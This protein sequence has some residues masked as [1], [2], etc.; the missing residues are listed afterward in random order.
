M[1]STA[2]IASIALF[3]CAGCDCGGDD[4]P[5]PC[6]VDSAP[7]GCGTYCDE[8]R[9]C[10]PGFFC[11]LPSNECTADCFT[12]TDCATN[13]ACNLGTGLCYEVIRPDA[14]PRDGEPP[15]NEGGCAGASVTARRVTPNVILIVDQSS[16]MNEGF[17]GRT[18]WQALRRSLLD[19]DDG[20]IQALD[21]QVRFGLAL[22]SARNRDGDTRLPQGEC[23]T[24]T[25][26]SAMLDNYSAIQ[27]VYSDADPIDETPTGDAIDAILDGILNLPDPSPDPTIFILATDGEPDRCEELNPQNGQEEAIAAVTRAYNSGIR[28]YIISVGRDVSEAHLQDV[29]NAGVGQDGAGPDADFWVAGDDQGLRDAL[30]AIIGGELSCVVQLDGSLSDPSEACMGTVELN[31]R[32]L[33]CDDP[34]GWELVDANHLELL[35]EACAELQGGPGANLTATFPC[36]VDIIF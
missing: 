8:G 11:D 5:G 34:D 4:P 25:E 27:E 22:Y 6:A 26:V 17:G 2:R 30:T 9:R 29:A 7:E 21:D 20:L 33:T 35:G 10:P 36:G 16:S 3:V 15:V 31:G 23:P 18:R 14:Q 1:T 28:T 19:P 24:L 32:D 13:E 12:N